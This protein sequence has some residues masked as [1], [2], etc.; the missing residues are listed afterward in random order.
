M[1]ILVGIVTSDMDNGAEAQRK[2]VSEDRLPPIVGLA[3][4]W[5]YW[6]VGLRSF[7]Y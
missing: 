4:G 2:S 3:R 6:R 5:R 7:D 1:I